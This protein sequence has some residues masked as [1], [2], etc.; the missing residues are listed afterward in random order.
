MFDW[1]FNRETRDGEPSTQAPDA[2]S[3]EAV[4]SQLDAQIHNPTFYENLST[5][6]GCVDLI[7]SSLSSCP[8]LVYQESNKNRI[9]APE[10]NFSKLIH[11]G[12]NRYQTWHGFLEFVM[13]Q[14]LLRGN[15]IAHIDFDRKT[16]KI[17]ELQAFPWEWCNVELLANG[18]LRYRITDC[19]GLYGKAGTTRTFLQQDML[20]IRDSGDLPYIG[21]SRIS[22]ASKV[23]QA[24]NATQEFSANLYLQ[25]VKPSGA[26]SVPTTLKS[27]ARENLS[28][29]LHNFYSG[30]N[31]GRA[32]ILENGMTWHPF[33][34]NSEDAEVLASRQFSTEEIAR[35][36][37]VPPPLVGD[38]RHGTFQNSETAGRWFAAFCLGAWA[39]KLEQEITRACLDDQHSLS[40]DLSALTRG[41]N[42]GRWDS[43]CKAVNQGILTRNEVRESEGWNPIAEEEPNATIS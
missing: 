43:W 10:H 3:W 5:V 1:L 9:E 4:G 38:L 17:I 15:A 11:N 6:F 26:L 7:A 18:K 24:A 8:A 14:V 40:I 23:F 2:I 29:D 16:G 13:R 22:R 33:C 12:P 42:A 34:L 20:H 30:Q 36:F 27:D 35:I 25:G 41:D 31:V 37:S 21:R 39:D 28:K 32:M 19:I